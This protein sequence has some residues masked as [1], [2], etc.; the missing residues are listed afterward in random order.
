VKSLP[1]PPNIGLATEIASISVSVVELLVL[2]VWGTVSTF[3]LYL[4]LFSKVGR[5]RTCGS[6]SGMSE[7]CVVAADVMHVDVSS[8]HQLITTSGVRLR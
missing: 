5:C 6:G 8:R 1:L 7:N 4:M 3:D 2:P